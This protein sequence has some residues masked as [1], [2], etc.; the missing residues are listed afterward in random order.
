MDAAVAAELQK[1]AL[2][3][4][5]S[6]SVDHARAV[7]EQHLGEA[8][9]GYFDDEPDPIPA[10]D[11]DE[12]RRLFR[13]RAEILEG[14][15]TSTDG[16]VYQDLARTLLARG[17]YEPLRFAIGYLP[18]VVA[19]IDIST[20]AAYN[21]IAEAY[22]TRLAQ[23]E[24]TSWPQG[25]R[26]ALLPIAAP[27]PVGH[28]A[29]VTA[30]PPTFD[31][32]P[33][34]RTL[35]DAFEE[36]KRAKKIAGKNKTADE[37]DTAVRRFD[38]LCGV[39]DLRSITT[40]M[41]EAFRTRVAK[42]PVR[43]K[44]EIRALPLAEQIARA[45]SE[46]LP[47]LL[48]PSIGKLVAGVRA[49]LGAAKDAKWIASNPAAGVRVEGAKWEG[50][51]RDHFSDA[52]MRRIYSSSLMTDPDAC[53]DTMFWILFLAPFHGSRPGE[54]C[55]LKPRDIEQEDGEWV[56]RFR[57]DRRPA[58]SSD[59]TT[60]TQRRQKNRSSVRDVPLHW[61]VLEA[62]FIEFVDVQKRRGAEWLFDDIEPDAYGDRYKE[63][64]RRINRALRKLG[65][66]DVDKA[67][68]ATRH[69]MKR[70]GR[71]RRIGKQSLDQLAGHASADVGDRYGRGL[72]V[73]TLKEDI[74]RLE[75]RSV[76]W[77][78]VVHCGL[79][80]IARLRQ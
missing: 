41:I 44:K 66:T 24:F 55:K 34:G 19:E 80:R 60:V 20:P 40:D 23:H 22:L 27:K 43:P 7:E 8:H 5:S 68:Y 57:R 74:D 39:V 76:D 79:K 16:L 52:D 10:I 50:D 11:G 53:D 54:H 36:W 1:I 75:F 33:T 6:W 26:E 64:S 13:V 67:F 21:A 58:R 49:V 29:A 3:V 30:F 9:T 47:T 73:E 14:K 65:I 35:R 59:G 42:L 17:T 18:Y 4:R 77:D 37:F 51:E 70:E 25:I 31:V 46:G 78:P 69:T 38:E 32:A 63:L 72:P 62:G 28:E 61:I 56:M 2:I 71:R 12:A 45:E 48:P 15:Q